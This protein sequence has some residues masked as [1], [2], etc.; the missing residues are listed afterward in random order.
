MVNKLKCLLTSNGS[1]YEVLRPIHVAPVVMMRERSWEKKFRAEKSIYI[2]TNIGLKI[3]NN[4]S[5]VHLLIIIYTH[6]PLY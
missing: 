2:Y 3:A 6:R 4:K 5:I 1:V